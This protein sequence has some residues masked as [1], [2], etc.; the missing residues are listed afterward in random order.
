M[1][2]NPPNINHCWTAL[3]MEELHRLG[4]E[5]V[6]IAPGSRSTPLTW[7]AA[8]HEKLKTVVHFDERGLAFHA[9]GIAKASRN[10][11][12]IICTSGSAVANLLPAVV[13][14]SQTH[15]P[16]ILLTADR[17]F[18][19]VDCGANQTIKQPGIFGEYVLHEVNLPCPDVAIAP[20]VL[21]TTIDHA[22]FKA[23]GS[24]AGPV[25]INCPF[26]EPLAP[27][28][29][30]LDVAE[31]LGALDRWTN[32]GEPWTEYEYDT[33]VLSLVLDILDGVVKGVIVAG[34]NS[35]HSDM[36]AV[37]ALAKKLNWPLISDVGSHYR[38]DPGVEHALSYGDLLANI[39]ME[40]R[41]N[42]LEAVIHVGGPLV[43]KRLQELFERVS[44]RV[45]LRIAKGFGKL[46]PGHLTTHRIGSHVWDLDLTIDPQTQTDLD[47]AWRDELVTA[48]QSIGSFLA[49]QF[50]GNEITEPGV[51]RA[52][53]QTEAPALFL[54]N[55]MPI[56]DADMYGDPGGYIASVFVNRGASGIDGNIATAAGIAR[57]TGAIT[58]VLG[59]LA[60]L[61]DLNS[62]AL[63]KDVN[64]VLVI[65]NNGGGGIFR[66]LPIAE[67]GD[68]AEEYFETPHDL[69]FESAA[70]QFKLPYHSPTT[71]AEF[72]T[73]YE[74]ALATHAS[75]I[76]EVRTD[77]AENAAFHKQ[78]QENIIEFMNNQPE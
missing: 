25:H 34:Q 19:L 30:G 10:P 28:V 42:E 63:L 64:V 72:N 46:D 13:E 44:P 69:T 75:A 71:M 70:A 20:N 65:I 9:L 5:T 59:D 29:D 77:R 8:H 62:L 22:V 18:E 3:M 45:Y 54:G 66:M 50:S 49:G 78:L 74:S 61:H 27:D 53:T 68:I 12:A 14:A 41:I 73:M 24:D 21:L 23:T 58:A 39:N 1:N 52:I 2:L 11:V 37:F 67:H 57:E 6:C 48:S 43:S 33:H 35:G 17:P 76:I 56:R 26:R 32:S 51:I 36:F 47:T 55:S 16:L 60:T 15:I 38:L 31:Y 4:V 7:A 40:S